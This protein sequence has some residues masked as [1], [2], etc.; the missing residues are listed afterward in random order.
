MCDCSTA[1]AV[2]DVVL[3][4]KQLDKAKVP[5]LMYN[6]ITDTNQTSAVVSRNVVC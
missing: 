2:G 4:K 5:K 3:P 1:T 6:R